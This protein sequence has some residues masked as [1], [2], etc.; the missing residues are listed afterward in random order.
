VEQENSKGLIRKV[1]DALGITGDESE[2]GPGVTV[3]PE[4]EIALERDLGGSPTAG[5]M[6]ILKES[7]AERLRREVDEHPQEKSALELNA[8]SA[9]LEDGE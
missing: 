2:S 4:R 8:E 1:T 9:R 3:S 7:D 5:T 6:R